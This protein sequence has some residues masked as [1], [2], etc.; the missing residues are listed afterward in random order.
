MFNGTFTQKKVPSGAEFMYES[1][2]DAFTYRIT[3]EDVELSFPTLSA[4]PALATSMAVVD[5]DHHCRI[6]TDFQTLPS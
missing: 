2:D 1:D 5:R 3:I 4:N 6:R